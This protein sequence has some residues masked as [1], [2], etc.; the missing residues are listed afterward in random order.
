MRRDRSSVSVRAR[1]FVGMENVRL[2]VTRVLGTTF[3]A[4]VRY[5]RCG[6]TNDASSAALSA[7]QSVTGAYKWTRISHV[8][9]E[10]YVYDRTTDAHLFEILPTI[11]CDYAMWGKGIIS[12][13]FVRHESETRAFRFGEFWF[14]TGCFDYSTVQ[15]EPLSS[16]KNSVL[17]LFVFAFQILRS[18]I[19]SFFV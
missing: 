18:F 1:S 10:W 15:I 7:S 11:S 19:L 3:A 2:P 12:I 14:P 17:K 13:R 8:R 9:S 4:T 5:G 6:A 16:K